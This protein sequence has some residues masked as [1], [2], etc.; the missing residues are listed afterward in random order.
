[1]CLYYSC[2]ILPRHMGLFWSGALLED[3][4]QHIE[5]LSST[6]PHIGTSTNILQPLSPLSRFA[7]NVLS[8]KTQILSL[9]VSYKQTHT[10]TNNCTTI[11]L[12][13][14][15]TLFAPTFL[16]FL[17]LYYYTTVPNY[18]CRSIRHYRSEQ[19]EQ[20]DILHCLLTSTKRISTF[21]P[22]LALV[23][24]TSA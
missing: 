23:L 11:Y 15:Y 17:I 13:S 16:I 6:S 14:Q 10:K 3:S 24:V 20:Q 9:P 8:D 19:I 18:H 22:V 12:C 4:K 5:F 21:S 2:Y 1:M 7:T